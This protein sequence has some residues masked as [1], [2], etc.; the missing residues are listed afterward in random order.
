MRVWLWAVCSAVAAA[1]IAGGVKV[2]MAHAKGPT[3]VLVIPSKL[4]GFARRARLEQQINARQLQQQVI[5]KSGGQASHVVSAVYEKSGGQAASAE[6]ILFIGGHL[7]GV[8]PSGF[9][10]SFTTEFKGARAVPA[11]PLG[12]S[13]AC[14]STS[15]RTVVALCVWADNDTFGLLV[16]PTMRV[17]QLSPEMGML[18]SGIEHVAGGPG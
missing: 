1:G 13:A 16:S 9:I 12:G 17:A 18:R 7:S 10:A 11:A 8:S 6:I 15:G 5:A 14:V 3:H 4:G 2:L